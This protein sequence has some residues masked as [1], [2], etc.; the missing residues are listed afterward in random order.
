MARAKPG[1]SWPE[2]N[3]LP[4]YWRPP[5]PLRSKLGQFLPDIVFLKECA[6][7]NR[8]QSAIEYNKRLALVVATF[9]DLTP[10][11]RLLLAGYI[12]RG[13]A[14]PRGR[15]TN[16]QR[17]EAIKSEYFPRRL[18]NALVDP[19]S[20]TWTRTRAICDIAARFNLSNEAAAKIFKD[21][22]RMAGN[23][24]LLLRGKPGPKPK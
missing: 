1:A 16:R 21:V 14:R 6:E 20:P 2:A 17:L 3:E 15:P 12:Q 19:P 10:A 11:G 4:E 23:P 18:G 22:R 9:G 8:A 5:E 24:V 7:I 13:F